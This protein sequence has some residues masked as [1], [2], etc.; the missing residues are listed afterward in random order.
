[1]GGNILECGRKILEYG[2]KYFRVWEENIFEC[3]RKIF[4]SMGE[5]Y[6]RELTGWEQHSRNRESVLPA[7]QEFS[8]KTES[9]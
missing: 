4:S 2:G 6:F 3:G 1:M 9:S 7:T 5:K 8:G